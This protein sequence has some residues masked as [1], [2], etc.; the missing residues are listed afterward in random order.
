MRR[1]TSA[2]SLCPGIRDMLSHPS[3]CQVRGDSGFRAETCGDSWVG[4]STPA[5]V[6]L[7]V[8][9]QHRQA[10]RRGP[11]GDPLEFLGRNTRL[12]R[13]SF[14]SFVTHVRLHGRVHLPVDSGVLHGDWHGGVVVVSWCGSLCLASGWV[15]C[16]DAFVMVCTRQERRNYAA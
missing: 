2:A 8:C 11:L 13:A 16:T 7:W 1:S 10:K 9:S 3:C 5:A 6:S 12:C 4:A 14:T 15:W